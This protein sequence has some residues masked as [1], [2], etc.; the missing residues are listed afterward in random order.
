MQLPHTASRI[1]LIGVLALLLIGTLGVTR[2]RLPATQMERVQV[3]LNSAPEDISQR[4]QALDTLLREEI[5]ALKNPR[6]I[7]ELAIPAEIVST[8]RLWVDRC[9]VRQKPF[10]D[11]LLWHAQQD[12]ATVQAR[13]KAPD[14]PKGWKY[15][16]SSSEH[17]VA[18]RPQAPASGVSYFGAYAYCRASGG[19]LPTSNEWQIIAGGR[20]GRLYPWGNNFKDQHKAWPYRD[21][22]L[23]AAQIC[24]LHPSTDTPAS[25]H[26]LANGVMEWSAIDY[27]AASYRVGG[28]NKATVHG[29]PPSSAKN[30][31][32]AALNATQNQLEPRL[33]SHQVGFRCVY[34][35]RPKSVTPWDARHRTSIV[36]AGEYQIGLPSDARLPRLL[37]VLPPDE[38]QKLDITARKTLTAWRM[39]VA[40]CETSRKHYRLFLRDPLVLLG[41][42]ANEAEPDNT[43]Y[44]PTEWEQQLQAPELPVVGINW[45]AADAFAR[46]VGGR[47]PSSEEWQLV[48]SGQGAHQYPW[49][50]EYHAQYS[51]NAELVD[52]SIQSCGSFERDISDGGV[53]DM[54][55][56]VSEWTRSITTGKAG[57]LVWVSGGSYLLPGTHTAQADF[58]RTIPLDYR[59][60]DVGFRVVF[61]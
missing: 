9:E 17:K 33:R 56:N 47:L 16:S 2:V 49:G 11:F 22:A 35:R 57:Y 12:P 40:R 23:N 61:D 39:K 50:N 31:S 43:S 15:A 29:V 55:A 54:A 53:H 34:W 36:E 51:M 48:S 13:I 5:S 59:A 58:R 7:N 41:L 18:G 24:G 37:S 27:T 10:E 46:W 25:V 4:A 38:I 32:I 52:A 30:R 42:F 21:G 6:L 44:I 19:R 45:W 8:R 14:E 28:Q 60:P 26:D 1:A 20:E 3:S